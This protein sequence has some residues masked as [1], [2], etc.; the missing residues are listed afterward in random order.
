MRR[1]S[2]LAV[3]V[4][5]AASMATVRTAP[6]IH[7]HLSL[8]DDGRV[9]SGILRDAVA[10]TAQLWAPYGIAVSRDSIETA[11]ERPL[12]VTLTM[13]D[14]RPCYGADDELGDIRF[15]P[16]G[17]PD[18]AVTLCYATILRLVTTPSVSM[19]PVAVQQRVM[20][21]AMGRALAHE[22]G[23][24]LLRWPHHAQR[25]LMRARLHRAALTDPSH[26]GFGLTD[27][28]LARLRIVLAAQSPVS[29]AAGRS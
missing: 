14:R 28:D 29:S 18:S 11:D 24:F 9:P 15:A 6:P 5:L 7:V 4:L 12:T 23:H 21:R 26:K 8:D 19:L 10:E 1:S 20:S 13:D 3:C 17:A 22:V 27:M 2:P 25:G 16:D